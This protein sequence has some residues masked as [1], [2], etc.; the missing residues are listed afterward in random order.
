[1]NVTA[2]LVIGSLLWLGI[3]YKQR[4]VAALAPAGADKPI[5]RCLDQ[6]LPAMR[7]YQPVL[8]L[9]ASH[10]IVSPARWAKNQQDSNREEWNGKSG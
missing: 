2:L 7:A 10:P 4:R 9:E 3:D 6:G 1:M 8:L 5:P